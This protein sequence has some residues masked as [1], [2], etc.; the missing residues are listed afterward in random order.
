MVA[1]LTG[2]RPEGA[3]VRPLRRGGGND[4]ASG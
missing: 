4:P 1:E 2:K 3:E